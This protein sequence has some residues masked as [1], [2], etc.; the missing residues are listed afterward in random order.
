MRRAAKLLSVAMMTGTG[1]AMILPSA[2]SAQTTAKTVQST[3]THWTSTTTLRNGTKID[4]LRTKEGTLTLTISR[5]KSAVTPDSA[6]GCVGNL[7]WNNVRTCMSI[8]GS[9]LYV[10]DMTATGYVRNTGVTLAVS[11]WTSAWG[12]FRWS[13]T[14]YVPPGYYEGTRWA[15]YADVPAYQYCGESWETGGKLVGKACETVHA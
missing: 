2:A 6:S 9:G 10:E 8:T 14:A 15:P 4:A 3:P 12:N 11:L 5:N 7:P 13:P 1:L